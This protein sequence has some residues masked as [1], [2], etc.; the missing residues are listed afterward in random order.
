MPYTTDSKTTIETEDQSIQCTLQLFRLKPT[1][2]LSAALQ[3]LTNHASSAPYV[4]KGRPHGWVHRPHNH[5]TDELLAHD[6][7]LFL[8]AQNPLISELVDGE[9][10]AAQLSI[11]IEIP[12]DQFDALVKQK[13]STPQP[14]PETPPLPEGWGEGIPSS[15]ILPSNKDVPLE[16]GELRLDASMADFLSTALPDKVKNSPVSLMNLFKYPNGSPTIHQQ[17]MSGFKSHFGSSAGATIKF[18]GPVRSSISYEETSDAALPAFSTDD[19]G[20]AGAGRANVS[21]SKLW[22]D[23]NLV[24]YDSLWHYAYM[25]STDVYKELNREKV[26]GLEDTCILLVSEVEVVR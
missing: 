9:M 4:L 12:K 24:Q 25:L 22:D 18:M 19:H 21:E 26:R 14:N 11:R 23:A 20:S 3:Y 13:D 2:P 8:L 10:V 1:T 6:W 5:N 7:D 16:P 17:Y 15:A